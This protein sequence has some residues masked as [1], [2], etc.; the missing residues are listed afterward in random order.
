MFYLVKD[1]KEKEKMLNQITE[2]EKRTKVVLQNLEEEK[3]ILQREI[4]NGKI[5]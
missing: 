5:E 2:A 4:D 1:V 3:E